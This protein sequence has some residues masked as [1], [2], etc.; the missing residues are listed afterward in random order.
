MS[1]FLEREYYMKKIFVI[2]LGTT[3]TKIAYYEDDKC[4]YKE[5]LKNPHQMIMGIRSENIHI[6]SKDE[7]HPIVINES[8]KVKMVSFSRSYSF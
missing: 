1:F 7:N 8:N 3:S 5:N 6:A 4:I 2:N